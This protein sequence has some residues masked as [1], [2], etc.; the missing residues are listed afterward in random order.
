MNMIL[1]PWNTGVTFLM[2]SVSTVQSDEVISADLTGTASSFE[3]RMEVETSR[4]VTLWEI[5]IETLLVLLWESRQSAKNHYVC[6]FYLIIFSNSCLSKA[7]TS[8]PIIVSNFE[9]NCRS[10][11][12]NLDKRDRDYKEKSHHPTLTIWLTKIRHKCLM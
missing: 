10:P 8:F 2:L 3:S 4:E 1:S 5:L 9:S 6:S 11:A 12:S 7:V